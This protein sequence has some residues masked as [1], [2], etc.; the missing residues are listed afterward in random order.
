MSNL[1]SLDLFP[2]SD[3]GQG[4]RL[5]NRKRNQQQSYINQDW[6]REIEQLQN[7]ENNRE[8]E[9]DK[10]H[11]H[12][13]NYDSQK[14]YQI[15]Y[16][17]QSNEQLKVPLK[18]FYEAPK[19]SINR[20][21]SRLKTLNRKIQLTQNTLNQELFNTNQNTTLSI[22]SIS[23]NT[24]STNHNLRTDFYSN[25]SGAF[26]IQKFPTHNQDQNELLRVNKIHTSRLKQRESLQS[27][28]LNRLSLEHRALSAPLNSNDQNLSLKRLDYDTFAEK[29]FEDEA[30][31]LWWH[32]ARR[33]IQ[34]DQLK[35]K[36]EKRKN[37]ELICKSPYLYSKSIKISSTL[38]PHLKTS[39]SQKAI[40]KL[41]KKEEVDL[42]MAELDSFEIKKHKNKII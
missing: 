37:L 8:F 22:N 23:P 41:L 13:I 39:N 20:K 31:R 42:A 10:G 26:K 34:R 32:Q 3:P 38:N 24:L 15:R 4:N 16:A 12:N 25:R 27:R 14:N 6:F 17:E 1:N 11:I 35:K 2:K 28:I 36:S 7:S 30:H 21:D 5:V 40:T 18:D 9:L 19:K 29:R 33:E